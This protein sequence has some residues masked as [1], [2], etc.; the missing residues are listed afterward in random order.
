MQARRGLLSASRPG[1]SPGSVRASGGLLDRPNPNPTAANYWRRLFQPSL[2]LLWTLAL[3]VLL[4]EFII[5]LPGTHK[6][7]K[8]SKGWSKWEPS[9]F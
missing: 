1:K 2:A 8:F 4:I 3:T 5:R 9:D 7:S 6:D